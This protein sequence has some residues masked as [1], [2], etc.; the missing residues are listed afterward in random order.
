[1]RAGLELRASYDC[2]D[3]RLLNGYDRFGLGE[4]NTL[5]SASISAKIP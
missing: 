5:I 2:A 3:E 1:M 4:K